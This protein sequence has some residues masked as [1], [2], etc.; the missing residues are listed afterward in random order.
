MNRE[1]GHSEAM[2][3]NLMGLAAAELAKGDPEKAARHFRGSLTISSDLGDELSEMYAVAGLACAA[4]FHRNLHL[5]GRLWGIAEA[6]E[7][8]PGM[9]MVSGERARYERIITP[10]QN[11]PA[12]QAGYEAGRDIELADAVRELL[13]T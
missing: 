6:A 2:V 12:F 3:S 1:S 11:D 10:L 13:T 9:A 7:N 4:A 8:R 5:A